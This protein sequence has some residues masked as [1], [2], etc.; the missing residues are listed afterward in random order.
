MEEDPLPHD[1]HVQLANGL[2]RSCG[3]TLAAMQFPRSPDALEGLKKF[4]GVPEGMKVPFA[5]NYHPNQ[6]CADN[7]R[8][9]Y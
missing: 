5:W 7:W 2:F 6:W 3:F 9:L 1:A 4:N 8:T